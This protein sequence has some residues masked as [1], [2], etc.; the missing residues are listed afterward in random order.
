MIRIKEKNITAIFDIYKYIIKD[1]HRISK[2]YLPLKLVK[3]SINAVY[4]LTIVIFPKLILDNVIHG[5]YGNAWNVVLILLAINMSYCIINQLLTFF[6]ELKDHRLVTCFEKALMNK[7]MNIEYRLVEL[8]GTYQLKKEASRGSG[9]IL[10]FIKNAETLIRN[11]I[12]LVSVIYLVVYLNVYIVFLIFGVIAFNGYI[13][14]KKNKAD[15]NMEIGF[16]VLYRKWDYLNY[17]C[18]DV[19]NAKEIRLHHLSGWLSK[20]ISHFCEDNE[21]LIRRSFHN[22]SLAQRYATV[23]GMIQKGVVYF[24]VGLQLWKKSITAGEFTQY[25]AAFEMISST[26]LSIINSYLDINK[27]KHLIQKYYDF[28]QHRE[29]NQGCLPASKPDT[30]GANRIEIRDVWFRYNEESEYIVKGI[31]LTISEG[32]RLSIVGRN[33]CGKTT[34][35]KLLLRLFQPERGKIL[36]NGKDIYEYEYDEYCKLFSVVFQDF[37]IFSF[38]VLDNIAMSDMSCDSEE[39]DEDS[40]NRVNIAIRKADLSAAIGELPKGIYTYINK[41]YV[42]EGVELSG[43][44]QQT[45]AMSRA[46]YRN[47]NNIFLDEPIAML[48]PL[49]ESRIYENFNQLIGNKTAVYISHRM[50]SSRFCDKIAYIEDGVVKEYGSHDELMQ[51]DGLYAT[52]YK[53][54]AKLF[55]GTADGCGGDK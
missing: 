6:F 17:I 53:K 54:Q 8:A 15:I 38:T 5:E 23:S 20:Q 44:T 45:L 13:N 42:A 50:S 11:S 7:I 32:E 19:S 31:S 22:S 24:Y 18:R 39:I 12:T 37:K 27:D 21:D 26:L 1:I 47:A 25:I 4:P 30:A 46:Y 52:M 49:K 3:I 48:D 10:S 2:A 36:L 16:A 33:G 51:L 28:I 29:D 34:L 41:N 9:H 43:G 14:Y 35:V 55:V 40:K